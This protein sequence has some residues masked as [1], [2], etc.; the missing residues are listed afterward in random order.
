MSLPE[1]EKVVAEVRR[2]A[3]ENPD[4]IYENSVGCAYGRRDADTGEVVPDCLIGHAFYALGV[5]GETLAEW[6]G[7]DSPKVSE[8]IMRHYTPGLVTSRESIWLEEVQSGQD[9][10]LPW[11]AAVSVADQEV[12]L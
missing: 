1:L 8:L 9:N 10:N 7:A 3:A 5:S 6:G 11:I 4:F 2:I 12:P